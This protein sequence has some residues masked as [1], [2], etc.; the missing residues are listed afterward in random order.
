MEKAGHP[1]TL[2]KNGREAV[3]AF[4]QSQFDLVLMDVQMPV[5]DSL[6]AT[7]AIRLLEQQAG[8]S[9]LP[10]VALT[11][12]AMESDRLRCLQA[13]MD[14]YASKPFKQDELFCLIEDLTS[15]AAAPKLA[16]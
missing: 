12:H 1:V 9:R 11:A 3:E 4:Q 8:L 13:G 2:A 15:P 14:A 7:M 5:M 10:I 6:A 16:S